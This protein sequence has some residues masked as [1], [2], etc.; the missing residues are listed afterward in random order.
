MSDTLTLRIQRN[1]EI[2]LPS[3]ILDGELTLSELGALVILAAV[4]EGHAGFD[5]PRMQDEEVLAAV[6][7][8]TERGVFNVTVQD[9]KLNISVDLDK[10]MP[11][12]SL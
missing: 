3:A 5:H 7:K 9:R 10:A 12:E 2:V 8:L 6:K 11:P 1:D 4:A